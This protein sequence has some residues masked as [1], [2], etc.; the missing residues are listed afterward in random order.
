V[1]SSPERRSRY[2]RALD[3]RPPLHH[4]PRLVRYGAAAGLAVALAFLGLLLFG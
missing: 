2:D 3:R 4:D 1:L